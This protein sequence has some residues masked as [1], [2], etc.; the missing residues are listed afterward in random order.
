MI[1]GQPSFFTGDISSPTGPGALSAK[2]VQ[3]VGVIGLDL[4]KT[5]RVGL[6]NQI[7]AVLGIPPGGWHGQ[8]KLFDGDDI[9]LR[10]LLV[11]LAREHDAKLIAAN[12]DR[13]ERFTH[14]NM[15]LVLVVAAREHHK[16]LTA[17]GNH[18]INSYH[19]G[20]LDFLWDEKEKLGLPRSVTRGWQPAGRFV[21]PESMREVHPAKIPSYDQMV[22]YA[23]QIGASFRNNFRA[24]VE[25][26]F[27]RP[28]EAAL[29]RTSRAALIVWQAY[30]FLAPGGTPFN[31]NKTLSSQ[32]G[33]HFGSRSVLG[34]IAYR[35]RLAGID[36]ELD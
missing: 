25:A 35:A 1:L 26:E 14:V 36:P 15:M 7:G 4:R 23:A 9:R 28:A 29:Q 22:V 27:G 18:L 3:A 20:G 5:G 31:G 19:E 11:K 2:E 17:G 13:A 33:Q 34:Y 24:N 21:N 6:M 12:L 10:A 30:A 8:A 32:Q 16:A